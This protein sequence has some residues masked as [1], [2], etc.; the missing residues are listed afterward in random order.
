MLT[1]FRV[2]VRARDVSTKHL[3]SATTARYVAEQEA[4]VAGRGDEVMTNIPTELLRTFV[5]L[6]DTRSFTRAAQALGVTQP[7]V[8]AQMK[9]LQSMLGG[10]LLDKSAPGVKLTPKGETVIA[11]ARRLLALNDQIL[12]LATGGAASGRLRVGFPP[13][14]FEARILDVIAKFQ[15]A[16]RQIRL[17]TVAD[18]SDTLLQALHGDEFDVVVALTDTEPALESDRFWIADSA[19][20]AASF[21]MLD[22]DDP[23]PLA[24][25]GHESLNRRMSCQALEQAG[26]TYEIVHTGS[27]RV[28]ALA[29][30]RAG[31]AIMS[32]PM[33]AIPDGLVM[34]KR[35]SRLPPIANAFAGVYVRANGK[36]REANELAA[37][38]AQ[39]FVARD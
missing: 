19:W 30:V 39:Q 33:H 11:H 5:A 18:H 20:I 16:N 29:A 32:C 9:R 8:S 6:A 27:S 24:V 17:Q 4:V 21:E 28:S 14:Y 2:V 34:R 1:N 23:I 3:R 31:L 22:A 25:L 38:L 15:L 13:E 26:R 12:E 35:T 37:A 7:A 36:S 10:E